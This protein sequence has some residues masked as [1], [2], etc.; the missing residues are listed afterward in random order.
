MLLLIS[1]PI[2]PKTNQFCYKIYEL[3]F[4]LPHSLH[5]KPH[6]LHL[7]TFFNSL[8]YYMPNQ[9]FESSF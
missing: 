8:W 7:T 1:I 2:Y 4:W 6:S 9:I 3:L 5:F